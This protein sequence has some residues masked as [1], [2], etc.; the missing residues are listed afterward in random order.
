MTMVVC[1]K[2]SVHSQTAGVLK[3]EDVHDVMQKDSSKATH[4]I[5]LSIAA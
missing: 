5:R 4:M 2:T 1:S 3:Q